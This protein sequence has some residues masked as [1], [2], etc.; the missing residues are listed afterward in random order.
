MR[1]RLVEEP[2]QKKIVPEWPPSRK[3]LRAYD[4]LS[5]TD[6]QIKF[7]DER[8]IPHKTF[9]HLYGARPIIIDCIQKFGLDPQRNFFLRFVSKLTAPIPNRDE[10]PKLQYIY[11]SYLN[12]KMDLKMPVL[13]N[14]TL[15]DRT[16]RDFRYTLNAFTLMSDKQKAA[17]YIKDVDVVDTDEFFVGSSPN[18][19]TS[20]IK[21]AG[22]RGGKGDTIF[23]TIERWAKDNEY[24]PEEIS[25]NKER[26]KE[27]EEQ[28]EKNGG[29]KDGTSQWSYTYFK[30]A[31]EK[32]FAN[33]SK[34]KISL[35]GKND[36]L[37]RVFATFGLSTLKF[38]KIKQQQTPNTINKLPSDIKDADVKQFGNP[39]N[40]DVPIYVVSITS[41]GTVNGAYVF[42]QF[43]PLDDTSV[44]SHNKLMQKNLGNLK[45]HLH[46]VTPDTDYATDEHLQAIVDAIE[47]LQPIGSK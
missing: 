5:T 15:Y 45:R 27:K 32:I 4:E 28:E 20:P 46:N 22:L 7:I 34:F 2:T 21:P 12:K 26:A 17:A 8:V 30:T 29:S 1:F 40:I 39:H 43:V 3:M 11:D 37:N 35:G 23:A 16:E 13:L 47:L 14:P 31:L 19:M 9:A 10:R 18:P 42:N 41:N 6:E 24:S 44:S 36:Y 25:D 33:K 38:P